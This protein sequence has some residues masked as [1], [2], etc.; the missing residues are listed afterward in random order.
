[1][2]PSYTVGIEMKGIGHGRTG[3]RTYREI[4]LI[5]LILS[6]FAMWAPFPSLKADQT[7]NAL[8]LH[9]Y[10]KGLG[11]TDRITQGIESALHNTD[12]EIELHFEYMDTKRI[13]D[14]QHFQNLYELYRHKF[15]NRR[16]DVIISSDDHA[17]NFL[18]SHHQD[19]FPGTPVVF[20]GV[21]D[22][23]ESMLVGHSLITGVVESFDIKANIDVAL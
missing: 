5:L 18:L 21:N 14:A 15:M 3:K 13:H 16:F 9:S 20:C 23:K 22:F 4:G 10:H 2:K 7:K 8:V 6:L 11:W 1:M 19:L 17:F 12:Q